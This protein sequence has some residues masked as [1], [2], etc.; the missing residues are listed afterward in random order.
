MEQKDEG[1]NEFELFVELRKT[2][3]ESKP[4]LYQTQTRFTK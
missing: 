2:K 4:H 1:F 3:E